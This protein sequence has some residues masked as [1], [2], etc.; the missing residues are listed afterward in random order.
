M[1]ERN[2]EGKAIF[3]S[4][5]FEIDWYDQEEI[6]NQPKQLEL[7][8]QDTRC[9]HNFEDDGENMRLVCTKCGYFKE[10]S[11]KH[12]YNGKTY[13]EVFEI[14]QKERKLIV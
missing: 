8:F 12:P 14:I 11:F 4:R 5:R 3:K 6:D 1:V 7:D 2:S 9:A 10:I 13:Q